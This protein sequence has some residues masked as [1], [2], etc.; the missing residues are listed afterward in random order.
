MKEI[1][2]N[3]GEKI[4]FPRPKPNVSD[5]DF[6]W[7][8]EKISDDTFVF[9]SY[10]QKTEIKKYNE[11]LFN[12][13]GIIE[14]EKNIK[15]VADFMN[16]WKN[17][18]AEWYRNSIENIVW[19]SFNYNPDFPEYNVSVVFDIKNDT[20]PEDEAGY[21]TSKS[22]IETKMFKKMNDQEKYIIRKN[23]ATMEKNLNDRAK[24]VQIYSFPLGKE[25][26]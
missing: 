4:G 10:G 7:K 11:G 18:A 12:I 16:R 3:L 6:S 26:A 5:V 24:E 23:A 13:W 21:W 17:L 2:R 25:F 15:L 8:M 22:I 20:D 14:S 9:E 19:V 1:F